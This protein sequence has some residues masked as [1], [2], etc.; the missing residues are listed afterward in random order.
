MWLVLPTRGARVS[1][2][3][4]TEVVVEG[5][6][7]ARWVPVAEATVHQ[8][9]GDLVHLRLTQKLSHV[10]GLEGSTDPLA[11]DTPVKL[12]WYR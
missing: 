5:V 3:R 8:L 10:A 9:D 6:R 7:S 12:V 1:V 4:Y 2:L 11:H